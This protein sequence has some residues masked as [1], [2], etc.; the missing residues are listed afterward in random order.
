MISK[1]EKS[2]FRNY[3]FRHLDGIVTAPTAFALVEKGVT[4]YILKSKECSL[5]QLTPKVG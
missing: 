5:N 3:L 4:A 1:I 2:T